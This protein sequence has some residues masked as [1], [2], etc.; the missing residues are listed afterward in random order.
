M[1]LQS[2]IFPVLR[3]V[4]DHIDD[5]DSIGIVQLKENNGRS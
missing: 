4:D 2:E 5:L 1:S 3:T